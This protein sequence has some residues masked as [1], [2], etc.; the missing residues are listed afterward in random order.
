MHWASMVVE[1]EFVEDLLV[2]GSNVLKRDKALL[3]GMDAEWII[4]TNIERMVQTKIASKI[5]VV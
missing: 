5:D 4:E 1:K 3:L 2:V